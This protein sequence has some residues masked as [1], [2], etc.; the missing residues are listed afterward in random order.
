MY[1]SQN[2]FRLDDAI[3]LFVNDRRNLQQST[4]FQ[5]TVHIICRFYEENEV[6]IVEIQ[7][8]VILLLAAKPIKKKQ[9]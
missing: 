1:Y 5:T 2:W 6:V 7:L 9:N 4:L 3:F 8:I